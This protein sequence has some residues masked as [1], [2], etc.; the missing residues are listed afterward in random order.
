[1]HGIV[2]VDEE[3]IYNSDVLITQTDLNGV[4]TFANRMF[5]EVSAYKFKELK[6]QSH[7][8]VR[9]PD[10]PQELFADLWRTIKSGEVWSGFIKNL[11]KDGLY[12]YSNIEILPVIDNDNNKKIQKDR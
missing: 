2:A 1:M 7:N 11:R 10:M 8:I 12:Y 9:H 5:C 3:Y 6:G 4:I